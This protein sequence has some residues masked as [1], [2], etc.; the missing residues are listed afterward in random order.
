M[1]GQG[2]LTDLLRG[3]AFGS[4]SAGTEKG[5]G[6]IECDRVY[7]ETEAQRQRIIK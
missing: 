2:G 7:E 3:R 6:W 4:F 5:V 1:E